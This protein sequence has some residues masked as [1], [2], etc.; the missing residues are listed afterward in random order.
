M[1]IK[2]IPE[3]HKERL[4]EVTEFLKWYRI[5]NGYSQ[6][7]LSESSGVHRNTIV[8]AETCHP[9]NLNLLTVFALAD[10]LDVSINEL[11]QDIE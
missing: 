6:Q 10:A 5:N 2:P 7:E 4:K 8:R 1:Y 3:H 11:F 9:V